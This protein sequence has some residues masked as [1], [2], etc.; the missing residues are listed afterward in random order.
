MENIAILREF[1]VILFISLPVVF[2]FQKLKIPSIVG[3][4]IAGV[5]IGP[6]GFKLISDAASV[7]ILAEVGV[8]LLL[9]SI[10]LEFSLS[11]LLSLGKILLVGGLLQVFLTAGVAGIAFYFI[12]GNPGLSVLSGFL[13]SLSSTAI[14]LKSFAERKETDSPFGNISL[15]IL[16]FQDLFVIPLMVV[17]PFLK[18]PASLQ[19][20]VFLKALFFALLGLVA[21]YFVAN[22]VLS[23]IM[24]Y[25]VR[26]KNREIFTL[27]VVAVCLG[28]A[29]FS[30]RIG[31]LSLSIGAFL[32]GIILS[33][34]RRGS[35]PATLYFTNI[36]MPCQAP[37]P[38]ASFCAARR[39][40]SKLWPIRVVLSASPARIKGSG[41]V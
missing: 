8:I 3:F 33:K 15:G 23:R 27:T 17:L 41:I 24:H 29:Y 37:L 28:T 16:L 32:A 25:I 7:N 19:A 30:F 35:E 36:A 13:I 12:T 1:V 38:A 10:G 14:V 34:P 11:R 4:I 40:A 22:F 9:F 20:G 31:G 39:N 2:L 18:D 26:L 5:L 21:L 6:G